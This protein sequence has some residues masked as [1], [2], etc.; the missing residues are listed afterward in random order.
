MTPPDADGWRK[1]EFAVIETSRDGSGSVQR[2]FRKWDLTGRV[3]RVDGNCELSDLTFKRDWVADVGEHVIK[4][5]FRYFAYMA[6]YRSEDDIDF[7]IR[8]MAAT[9]GNK[10]WMIRTTMAVKD[11]PIMELNPSGGSLRMAYG[12]H[13]LQCQ[14]EIDAGR[15]TFEAADVEELRRA[16]RGE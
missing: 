11:D 6:G 2:P 13:V 16:A 3:R 12:Q 7:A 1:F 14:R 9:P 8:L 15:L 10:D 5:C 4:K